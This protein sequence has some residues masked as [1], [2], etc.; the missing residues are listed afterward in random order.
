VETGS[1]D[2]SDYR[3]S[4]FDKGHLAPAADM[5]WDK[6][7]MKE[8]FYLSNVCPQDHRFNEGIWAELEKAARSWVKNDSIEY[9]VTGPVLPEPDAPKIGKDGVTVPSYFY[10]V[11]F[12]PNPYPKAIAF[13]IPNQPLRQSFWKYACTVTDVEKATRIRFFPMLPDDISKEIKN[14]FEI[15]DWRSGTDFRK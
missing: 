6:Q 5:K 12:S 15:T 8:S 1:A 10:K 14:H 2:P 11:I 4:G 9:I 13:V 3:N 7:V